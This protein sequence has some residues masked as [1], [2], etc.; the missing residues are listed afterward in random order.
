MSRAFACLVAL[1]LI[2]SSTSTLTQGQRQPPR[3]RAQPATGTARIRGQ[4]VAADDGRPIRRAMVRASAPELREQRGTF[5]DPDG[6]YELADLPA[7]RFTVTAFKAGFV[8]IS[9]GQTRP[10]EMGRPI[11]VRD[12]QTIDRIDFALPRGAAITGRIVDEYGEPVAGGA[13]QPMQ[14]RYVNG[15]RQPTMTGNGMFQTPDTGEFRLWGLPPGDYLLQASVNGGGAGPVDT[16]DRSGYAPTYYP[17]T[18]NPA[19]AQSVR[20]E[21]GQTLS[22]IE[23]MLTPARAV[24]ITGTTLDSRGEPLRS[25]FVSAMPERSEMTM[26][27]MSG[28]PSQVRPDGTFTISV[29]TA[30]TYLLRASAPP[31][32]TGGRPEMLVATVTVGNDDVGGVVLVPL[33]PVT[34]T[35]RI[36]FDQPAHSIDPSMIRVVAS[37]KS[38]GMSMPLPMPGSP[39]VNQDF[40]FEL[41]APPGEMAVWA[42]LM[43]GTGWQV[44]SV[45]IAGTDVTDRGIELVSGGTVKD[46]E[47]LMTNRVQ[48]V[49]GL[50]TNARGEIATDVTVFAFAQDRGR[51]LTAPRYAAIG[52][53]D[54]HGRYSLRTLPPGDYYA[55]AVEH[56]DPNRGRGDPEYLEELSRGAVRF[57]LG[58]ADAKTLDLKLTTLR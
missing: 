54:Q 6:R 12:R 27:A 7:G 18:A 10:Y 14:L 4:V 57:T 30:G 13:V 26:L 2:P 53:P 58:E 48:V 43:G 9:H 16:D 56:L 1:L 41:K 32:D 8:T 25:G 52:R 19:E 23:I 24:R 31:A 3:D 34:V 47:I 15:R 46:V 21:A 5:T 44:K 29:M 49:T 20:V 38:P 39:V 50:V 37:P 35:G 11:D 42:T 55:V 36:L 28:R 51:W 22:G 17:G 33:Q 40:T 45:T